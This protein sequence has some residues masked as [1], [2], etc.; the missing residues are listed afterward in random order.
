MSFVSSVFS[1]LDKIK[2]YQFIEGKIDIPGNKTV[3]PIFFIQD[4]I[5]Y[6]YSERLLR[7]LLLSEGKTHRLKKTPVTCLSESDSVHPE[8]IQT[9]K[10]A[11]VAFMET[12]SK[13]W[14]ECTNLERETLKQRDYKITDQDLVITKEY[15]KSFGF[16]NFKISSVFQ[17]ITF[18]ETE[19]FKLIAYGSAENIEIFQNFFLEESRT[20]VKNWGI[21][22]KALLI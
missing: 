22:K 19:D 7:G 8:F 17:K 1:D 4:L 15:G 10:K 13:D 3:E 5:E 21:G 2:T 11:T 12:L 18:L 6:V 14:R 20:C 16:H 9:L